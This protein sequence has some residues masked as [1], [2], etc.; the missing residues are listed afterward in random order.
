MSDFGTIG[1]L[2]SAVRTRA[3]ATLTGGY[4]HAQISVDGTTIPL[5][6]EGKGHADILLFPPDV[7]VRVLLVA[8]APIDYAFSVTINGSTVKSQGIVSGGK[9]VKPFTYQFDDFGL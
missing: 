8:P 9:V 6:V 4:E 7:E 2:A 5:D 3:T 1:S